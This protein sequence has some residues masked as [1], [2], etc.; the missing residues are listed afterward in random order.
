MKTII[1]EMSNL[2]SDEI[3]NEHKDYDGC[4]MKLKQIQNNVFYY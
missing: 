2:L 3:T 4:V 1:G